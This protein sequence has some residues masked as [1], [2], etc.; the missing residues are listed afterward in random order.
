[1][2]NLT[3]PGSC[4]AEGNLNPSQPSAEVPHFLLIATLSREAHG[5]SKIT[6]GIF[7]LITVIAMTIII[8]II[9]EFLARVASGPRPNSST[10]VSSSFFQILVNLCVCDSRKSG[11]FAILQHPKARE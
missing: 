9:N 1:M 6:I 7:L 4:H 3:F 10:S 5:F 11:Q 8:A 2:P